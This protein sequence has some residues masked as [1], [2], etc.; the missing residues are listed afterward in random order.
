MQANAG[1]FQDGLLSR[2][3]NVTSITLCI[4]GIELTSEDLM[5]LLGIK[6]DNKLIFHDH[7]SDLCRRASYQLNAVLSFS[8]M[9]DRE[10]KL[11]LFEA[12]ILS[13]FMYCPVVWHLCN[14]T[15]AR[16]IE[17]N[18]GKCSEICL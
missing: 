5:K 2:D 15:D 16:K 7:V 6:I 13:N 3:P 1:K 4:N 8:N 12:F 10:C 14:I 11:K 9:L 17:T 18:P